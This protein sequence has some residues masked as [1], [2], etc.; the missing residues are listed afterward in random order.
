VGGSATLS[1]TGGASGNPVVFSVDPSSGAGV[2]TV[3]G[4]NGTTLKYTAAGSCVVDANQA[5][6]TNYS[7]APQVPATITVGPG[8]Q[9]ISFSGPGSGTVGSSA[10]L[11]ATGGASGN[12]VVF[13]VDPSSGAGVC[14]VSGTNG[15]MLNYTAAGSCVVD[16]N[17][18][19]S[20]NYS[21]APQ[22][23]ATITVKA[24]ANQ[25]PAITS[26][27]TAPATVGT[28]FSFTVSTTGYPNPTLSRTGT[29]PAG[30]TFKANSNGTATI[31]GTPT[32]SGSYTETITANNGVGSRATQS[33]VITVG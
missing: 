25:A 32:K 10:T 15:T 13:S 3:S 14:T 1:A 4:T 31:S 18:A 17:Q 23:P 7:A 8:P 12:P 27:A 2:C 11:S 24:P 16:A 26:P 9:A 28:A 29:L 30:L 22:V 33:L 20:T 5:G 6:N 21:A 19:G